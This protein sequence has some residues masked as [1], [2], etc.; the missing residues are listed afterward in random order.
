LEEAETT[1]GQDVYAPL[2]ENQLEEERARKTSLEQRGVAVISTSGVL[3]SFLFGLAA[4]V[5]NA[6][7]FDLPGAARVLLVVTVALFVLAAV[8]GL[9]SNWPLNYHQVQIANLHRLVSKENW[10]APP[11]IAAQRVAESQVFILERARKL[12]ALK[13]RTLLA[14][15]ITQILAVTALATAVSIIL[16]ETT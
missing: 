8:G 12:N 9:V 1:A 11:R 15:L 10:N 5:T 4:V 14:A 7:N 2:V 6:K 3:V 16:I 13:A